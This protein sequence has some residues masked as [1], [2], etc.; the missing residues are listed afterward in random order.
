MRA[1]VDQIQKKLL[2]LKFG[3]Q[4][5]EKKTVKEVILVH[6]KQSVWFL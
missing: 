4:A 5:I 2:V 3:A 6:F 1:C